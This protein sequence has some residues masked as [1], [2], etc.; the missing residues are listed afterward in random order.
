MWGA[1]QTAFE[2]IEGPDYADGLSEPRKSQSNKPLPNARNVSRK[3]HGSNADHSNPDSKTLSHLAMIWGQFL[4]HDIT[5]ALGTGIN[6]ELDTKDPECVNIEIPEDDE[7]FR[8]REVTFIEVERDSPFKPPHFCSLRPREHVRLPTPTTQ[9]SLDHNRRSRKRDRKK[10]KR[11][12]SSD[13]DSVALITP[14]T[15]PT[16][17]FH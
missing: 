12:D 13:S 9:F 17:D 8:K 14:L 16:F 6:C 4:D 7:V 1:A 3:V 11:S 15:S 2:R 10:W 5:L